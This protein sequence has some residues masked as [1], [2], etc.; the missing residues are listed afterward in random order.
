MERSRVWL[1][2]LA[3]I[4]GDPYAAAVRVG[5]PIRYPYVHGEW[6]LAFYQTLFARVEGSA[7]MPSAARPFTCRVLRSLRARA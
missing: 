1:L 4:Q 5:A 6:P 3:Q 2:W 7:E